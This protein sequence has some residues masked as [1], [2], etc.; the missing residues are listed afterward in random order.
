M[1][2]IIYKNDYNMSE[3]KLKSN[4]YFKV[5]NN[6]KDLKLEILDFIVKSKADKILFKGDPAEMKYKQL[7]KLAPSDSIKSD[8]VREFFSD[9]FEKNATEHCLIFKK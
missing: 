5:F 2:Y 4:V 6:N 9:F 1:I 3:Y 7:K 8:T